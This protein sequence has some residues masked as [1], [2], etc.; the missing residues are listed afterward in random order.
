MGS[1][2]TQARVVYV[3]GCPGMG[4][5]WFSRALT[6]MS[7]PNVT[8]VT[9]FKHDGC[10][11][12][13]HERRQSIRHMLLDQMWWMRRTHPRSVQA[14]IARHPHTLK[15][16]DDRSVR[17]WEAFYDAWASIALTHRNVVLFRFE[18]LITSGCTGPLASRRAVATY[19]NA[20][21]DVRLP[22]HRTLAWRAWNYSSGA[23]DPSKAVFLHIPK[24]AG[25]SVRKDQVWESVWHS[26]GVPVPPIERC[27][28]ATSL[29][30]AARR[31]VSE[32]HHYGRQFAAGATVKGWFPAGG[33]RGKTLSFDDFASDASTHNSMVK[34]LSGCNMYDSECEVG[35]DDVD[36]IVRMVASG[37]LSV[38]SAR[39]RLH[40]G[41]YAFNQ[42]EARIA[43]MVN[44][45]DAELVRRVRD[46]GVRVP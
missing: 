21:A 34:L 32:W 39:L 6:C 43:K 24:T 25:L 40:V 15:R 20:R 18:D 2:L 17:V 30:D 22:V 38:R 5:R 28:V 33:T 26:R 27:N 9:R 31:Y 7:K 45:L 42:T 11:Q 3:R 10:T 44:A 8:V 19:A 12:D 23:D 13:S 1:P 35:M 16:R 41:E 36:R 4:T 14:V 37:C 46:L 29:R